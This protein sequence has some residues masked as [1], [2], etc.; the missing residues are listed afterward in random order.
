VKLYSTVCVGFLLVF[1]CPD[2]KQPVVVSDFCG[3]MK[4]E[5]AKLKSLS[6]EEINSLQR[7]R[8]EAIVSIRRKYAKEC[9]A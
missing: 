9:P 2:P 6:D 3:L 4:K 7:P 1:V 5:V 8:R